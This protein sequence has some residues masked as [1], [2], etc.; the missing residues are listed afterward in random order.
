MRN[1]QKING[2]TITTTTIIKERRHWTFYLVLT[3]ML[4]LCASFQFG[5]NLLS[6]DL[7]SGQIRRYF[8][9]ETCREYIES[10]RY[11]RRMNLLHDFSID[12]DYV[13]LYGTKFNLSKLCPIRQ[14]LFSA[15][16]VQQLMRELLNNVCDKHDTIEQ[17]IHIIE[18]L[19]LIGALIGSLA[20]KFLLDTFGRKNSIIVHCLFAFFGSMMVILSVV[21]DSMVTF[22]VSRCFFGIQAGMCC[23]LV[24]IYLVEIAPEQ[25]R[26]S[27]CTLHSL[28]FIGG[29][30][31]VQM[32]VEPLSSS[33]VAWSSNMLVILAF[34]FIPALFSSIGLFYFSPESPKALFIL[35]NDEPS[36]IVSLKILRNS[37]VIKEELDQATEIKRS[38][39]HAT[40]MNGTLVKSLLLQVVH[41]LSI[42][43]IVMFLR[44]NERHR[45]F[46]DAPSFVTNS[47]FMSLAA[48]G[49]NLVSFVLVDTFVSVRRL[50]VVSMMGA[51]AGYTAIVIDI[52][53]SLGYY[54]LVITPNTLD[55]HSNL[56]TALVGLFVIAY[57]IGL[58]P[59]SCYYVVVDHLTLANRG[60][61]MGIFSALSWICFMLFKLL[62]TSM[63][64]VSH[65]LVYS[66]VYAL[67]IVVT[68]VFFYTKKTRSYDVQHL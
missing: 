45:L 31:M 42:V 2:E 60:L 13:H 11:F 57:S 52:V 56:S 62:W 1:Q 27:L 5:F 49:A 23:C 10:N 43:N 8:K 68:L 66:V 21:K 61:V 17:M 47:F 22:A 14:D 41:A 50:L 36:S 59:M 55:K 63:L 30:L 24:P 19:F 67:F 16:K 40:L 65:F 64:V 54:E 51:L 48:F 38:A 34:P 4:T 3:T 58:A 26:N 32:V 29:L 7:L 12:S 18:Y 35:Y 25:K 44:L 33:T 28:V 6:F 46:T 9:N 39:V 53:H 20:C 37:R 15:Y